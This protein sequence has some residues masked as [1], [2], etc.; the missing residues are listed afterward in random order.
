MEQIGGD[1]PGMAGTTSMTAAIRDAVMDNSVSVVI[2]SR[3]RPLALLRALRSVATQT[4]PAEEVIIV[5]DGSIVP[6]CADRCQAVLGP[7]AL[8]L[9]RNEQPLGP[10]Q[11]RNRGIEAASSQWISLLDDDDEFLPDKLQRVLAKVA[12]TPDSD[13]VYHPGLIFMATEGITYA[14]RLDRLRPAP[15][16]YRDLLV[17]NWIGG[18][19]LVTV[20]RTSLLEV[21]GFDPDLPACEDF[22]LWLRL[23]RHG[24]KMRAIDQPLTRCWIVTGQPSLSKQRELNERAIEMIRDKHQILAPGTLSAAEQRAHRAWCL[25]GD[26]RRALYN[27]EGRRALRLLLRKLRLEPNLADML[28]FVA[29]LFGPRLVFRLRA[30]LAPA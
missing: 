6:V 9:L 5:D 1:G 22:E 30:L 11:A 19:P 15:L 14:T 10:A 18:T 28:T 16:G 17:R 26:V 24:A 23:A 12:E 27:Y 2:A 21:G 13:A 3:D 4:A 20:R 7:I 8:T 29:L 25:S